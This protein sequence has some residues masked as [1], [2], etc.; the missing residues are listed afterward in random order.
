MLL[1][2]VL[3]YFYSKSTLR[4]V[5]AA[6]MGVVLLSWWKLEIKIEKCRKTVIKKILSERPYLFFCSIVCVCVCTLRFWH[7]LKSGKRGKLVWV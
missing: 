1:L 5:F 4:D 7:P 6:D 3:Y 2:Q